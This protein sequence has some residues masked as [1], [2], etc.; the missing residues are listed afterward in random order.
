MCPRPSERQDVE[1]ALGDLRR[2]RTATG[3]RLADVRSA[4]AGAWDEQKN[5]LAAARDELGRKADEL[6]ARLE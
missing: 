2:L 6:S 4:S 5:R 3:E 1:A